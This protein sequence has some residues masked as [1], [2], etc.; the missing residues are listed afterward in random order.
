MLFPIINV[1]K[2]ISDHAKVFELIDSLN[3]KKIHQ[4]SYQDQSKLYAEKALAI[5]SL[6]SIKEGLNYI[7]EIDDINIINTK[8]YKL[9]LANIYR[10]SEESKKAAPLVESVFNISKIDDDDYLYLCSLIGGIKS[11]INK[12]D[13]GMNTLN[14][15]LSDIPDS[16]QSSI[17]WGK[18][19]I[20]FEL[21]KF[22]YRRSQYNES[23]K[24]ILKVISFRQNIFS[25]DHI[26]LTGAYS[27]YS[28]I[29]SSLGNQEDA[30]KYT[31]LNLSILEKYYGIDSIQTSTSLYNT[32]TQYTN[33]GQYLEAERYILRSIK[34]L[35][36][37]DENH[38]NL[39]FFY[40][41]LGVNYIEA[42]EWNK[43]LESL[44]KSNHYTKLSKGEDSWYLHWTN[45][46]LAL[47]YFESNDIDKA[48]SLLDLSYDKVVGNLGENH[49]I[50]KDFEELY[51]SV[52]KQ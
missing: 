47:I 14:A 1:Y 44:N 42:K 23:E 31:I 46:L 9:A 21:A 7:Q 45:L 28:A 33:T 5:S 12:T 35:Q 2:N 40:R 32:G 52:Y 20:Q 26:S 39:G 6:R 19:L 27:Y 41:G 4:L 48:K 43:A 38:S 50:R 30:I 8:N 17:L 13:I 36:N 49:P 11:E 25:N 29:H 16:D 18:S 24:H 3:T 37:H 51:N 10:S 22:H 15:C 34:I